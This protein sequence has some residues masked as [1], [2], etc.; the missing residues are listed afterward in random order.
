MK[1]ALIS[2]V[3]RFERKNSFSPGSV[4]Q[5]TCGPHLRHDVGLDLHMQRE[6]GVGFQ[7]DEGL[8]IELA[9]CEPETACSREE[10][11]LD[12]HP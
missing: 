3:S 11:R 2:C 10:I 12:I 6:P 8:V 9:S 1:S 4:I 7:L 5:A